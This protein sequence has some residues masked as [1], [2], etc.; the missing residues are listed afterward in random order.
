MAK[1][2]SMQK[3][4]FCSVH[5]HLQDCLS[6]ELKQSFFPCNIIFAVYIKSCSRTLM[7]LKVFSRIILTLWHFLLYALSLPP[8]FTITKPVQHFA[9]NNSKRTQ[10]RTPLTCIKKHSQGHLGQEQGGREG[11]T[12]ESI[13]INIYILSIL[14]FS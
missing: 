7:C 9:F 2:G 14:I 8:P 10:K 1:M 5:K 11:L 6:F 4:Q 12:Q 13:L 3:G